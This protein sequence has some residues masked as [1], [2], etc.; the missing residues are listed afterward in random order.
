MLPYIHLQQKLNILSIFILSSLTIST[1][2]EKKTKQNK[3]EKKI[4]S[5]CLNSFHN[6]TKNVYIKMQA[7]KLT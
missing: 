4:V 6:Y 5:D 3:T 1:F 2:E 7:I